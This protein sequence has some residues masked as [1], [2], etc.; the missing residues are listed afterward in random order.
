MGTDSGI[1]LKP[2]KAGL[3][4]GLFVGKSNIDGGP[5]LSSIASIS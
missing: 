1:L 4:G 5:V 2:L 3:S